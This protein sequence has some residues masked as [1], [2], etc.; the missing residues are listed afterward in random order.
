MKISVIGAGNIG[1]AIAA[2]L[3]REHQVKVYSSKPELFSKN[4]VYKDS[5]NK[6]EFVSE[7]FMVSSD[8]NL[9]LNGSDVI[10]VALPTFMIKP[11]CDKIKQYI[12]SDAIVGFVPGAG[13]I[14]YLAKSLID[15]GITVFGFE[16]VPYVSRVIKYGTIVSASKKASY[17]TATFQKENGD[18]VSEIISKLFNRPCVKMNSFV[19]MSLTP[20]LHTSR[21]YD[22]YKDYRKGQI[23]ADNPFFYGEW[24]DSASLICFDMDKELHMV[25]NGLTSLGI[26]ASETVPYPIHYESPTPELLTKKLKSIV[27]LNKIKGPVI[28]TENGD[29]LLDLNSRYFT[30]SY[31]YRLCLVKGFAEILGIQTPVTDEVLLWYSNLVDKEYY[32]GKQFSG[33]DLTECNIPQNYGIQTKKSLLSFYGR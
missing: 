30:E 10:F 31:P 8:Y 7:L 13:G 25:C 24:R 14:E 17:K 6:Q 29:Y 33:K 32:V 16:R 5:E 12:K 2:D 15:C 19:S 26:D 23:L 18:R 4:L 9:V 20:T 21:L 28:E 3:A 22:L 1:T 11:T 27:S